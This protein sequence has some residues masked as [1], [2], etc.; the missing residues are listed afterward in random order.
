[1]KT[2]FQAIFISFLVYSN[3]LISQG[4]G[5]NDFVT[6]WNTGSYNGSTANNQ[7]KIPIDNTL[8]YNYNVDWDNDGVF[9]EF[10]ITES[11]T[12][13]FDEQGQY[14]IRISGVFP[15]IYFYEQSDQFKIRS[16]DQWG[17]QEWTSMKYAFYDCRY[18]HINATDTPNLSAVTD[19]RYMFYNA[20]N[21]NE[22]INN[23]DVSNVTNMESLFSYARLYNQPLNNWNTSNATN[24][25]GMFF[26][27]QFFNQD[28]NS[29][30]TSNVLDMRSMFFF[31]NN[32][33]GN[34]GNWDTSSV[35]S[36]DSM[37]NR[38]INFNNN[39]GNWDTSNVT[40]MQSMFLNASS[41][42]QNIN[43]WDVSNVTDFHDMFYKTALFNQELVFNQDLNGWDLS[44]AINLSS[45]FGNNSSFNGNIG[46]WNTSNVMYMY[47]MFS[48]ATSFNQ[49]I[50][51]WDTSSVIG[52]STMFSGAISFNQDIGNWDT[53][54]VI[55]MEMMFYEAGSFDQNLG[56]WNISSLEDAGFMFSR[57]ALS[58][59]NYDA[60]LMGWE[61]QPHNNSV[62][63]GGG[64]SI[65][66]LGMSARES[67]NVNN[68]WTIRDGAGTLLKIDDKINNEFIIYPNPS[69]G[70]F[71]IKMNSYSN[72]PL[73]YLVSDITGKIILQNKVEL[74]DSKSFAVNLS[75]FKSGI[76]FI[77][78]DS[79]DMSVTKKIIVE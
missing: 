60:L 69:N 10:G 34:I 12:H 5:A 46:N 55:S 3:P 67:L 8:I 74:L 30:D 31:T 14:T 22:S 20:E 54:N 23:W 33:N 49:N 62:N 41:F 2:T 39:I 70:I 6:T 47:S 25:N 13:T 63:F 36:M 61:Q 77:K 78:L 21:F 72:L 17:S 45:M 42:N 76:Y 50:G 29:W 4:L 35:T 16:V 56:N 38:A 9:D 44:S 26:S 65:P 32:F 24:M 68:Y 28:L 75:S 11:I 7:I 59:E 51:N 43:S 53:S 27:S 73:T 48:N 71:K 66:D 79:S 37:F 52:V 64:E 40:E 15:R 18:L 1:M 58:T 19:M 57:T